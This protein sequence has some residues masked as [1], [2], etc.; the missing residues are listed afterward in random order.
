[1]PRCLLCLVSG[2]IRTQ[3]SKRQIARDIG[4]ARGTAARLP[5]PRSPNVG[6]ATAR[7][8]SILP[9]N[10]LTCVPEGARAGTRRTG[11]L[12]MRPN[13]LMLW[14]LWTRLRLLVMTQRQRGNNR[15]GPPHGVIS[16]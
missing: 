3:S 12:T 1:M 5:A 8:L 9:A 2:H 6:P 10:K 4:V 16:Q 13:R 11:T 7:L 14:L 15:G